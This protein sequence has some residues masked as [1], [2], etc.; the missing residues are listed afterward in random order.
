[1]KEAFPRFGAG[2]L[3]FSSRLFIAAKAPRAPSFFITTEITESTEAQP[4]RSTSTQFQ[5]IFELNSVKSS[6]DADRSVF[7]VI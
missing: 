4:C 1:M 2:R 7:S 3:F 6:A 5:V